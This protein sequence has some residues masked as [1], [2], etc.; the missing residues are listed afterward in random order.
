[1]NRTDLKKKKKEVITTISLKYV[2]VLLTYIKCI[3]RIAVKEILVCKKKEVLPT[4]FKWFKV[5]LFVDFA[6]DC[7]TALRDHQTKIA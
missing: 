6:V 7:Q 3:I 5:S 2:N 1:M 4:D